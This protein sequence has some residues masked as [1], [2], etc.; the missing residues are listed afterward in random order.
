MSSKQI[1]L[2][3]ISNMSPTSAESLV[4]ILNAKRKENPSIRTSPEEVALLAKNDIQGYYENRW[5]RGDAYAPLALEV[6]RNTGLLGTTANAWL[7][8][9]V[10]ASN[11]PL[12]GGGT[13]IEFIR[14]VNIGLANAHRSGV[15]AD[16]VRILGLLSRNQI[17]DYHENYFRSLGLPGLT[18]GGTV[19]GFMGEGAN[20]LWCIAC[21]S[22][23]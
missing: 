6:V 5:F 14:K 3:V 8:T 2:T 20:S 19:M 22:A 7:F 15:E 9:Q 21:D 16:R 1:G 4:G 18:F 17:R 23:P 13:Y 11:R 12:P 10:V